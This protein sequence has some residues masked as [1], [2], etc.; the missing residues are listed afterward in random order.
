[1][2]ESVKSSRQVKQKENNIVMIINFQK[3]VIV[4][5]SK[6]GEGSL[7]DVQPQLSQTTQIGSHVSEK[8]ST[9]CGVPQGSVLGLLLF[10]IYVNDIY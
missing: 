5:A 4:K 2:V 9:L 3:N 6:G 7:G 1:M 8:Q 10:L